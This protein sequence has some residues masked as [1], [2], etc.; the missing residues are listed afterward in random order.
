MIDPADTTQKAWLHLRSFSWVIWM[1]ISECGT[2]VFVLWNVYPLVTFIVFQ[3]IVRILSYQQQRC[4]RQEIYQTRTLCSV[5]V[6]TQIFPLSSCLLQTD[7]WFTRW[8]FKTAINKA[9]NTT[10][11]TQNKQVT[12]HETIKTITIICLSTRA[13][14][15][16]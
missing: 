5:P 9:E 15:S 11:H 8:T 6:T 13:L 12:V 3:G 14:R 1:L 4:S 16:V 10:L 7:C 2:S